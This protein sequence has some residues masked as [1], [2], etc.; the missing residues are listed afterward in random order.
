[1]NTEIIKSLAAIAITK[2][3]RHHY[4]ACFLSVKDGM[5]IASKPTDDARKYHRA[6][7]ITQFAQNAG[8]T[9]AAWNIVGTELLN[10]YNK[11]KACQ[12]HPKP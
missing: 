2:W 3:A 7:I 11:E 10:L 6:L 4:K 1:M 9:P 8:L 5:V 12:T